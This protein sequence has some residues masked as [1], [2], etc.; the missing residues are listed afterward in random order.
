MM[1]YSS[2]VAA[3]VVLLFVVNIPTVANALSKVPVVGSI[4]QVLQFGAAA[5][6]Q[7]ALP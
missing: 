4:V 2:V 6:G 5:S 3:A 1:R 7:T